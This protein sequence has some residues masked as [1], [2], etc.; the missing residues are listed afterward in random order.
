L[1]FYAAR[2]RR[3]LIDVVAELSIV[4]ESA[5]TIALDANN[6]L[7]LVQAPRAMARCIAKAEESGLCFATVRG[8]NHLG[9][10]GAY[11]LMAARRG[12]GGIAMTNASPLVVPTFGAEARMGT[13]PIAIAVPTGSGP[14]DP[15]LV[16]DMAT[17]AVAWGKIEIARREGKEIPLGWAVDALGAPTTDPHA[18]CW[19][20]PLGGERGHKGYALGT[21]IDVLC[22]PLAGAAWS[23]RI[24]GSRGPEAPASIG[25]AFMAWRIDAFRD[26]DDFFRDIKEMVQE[27]RATPTAAGDEGRSVL[28]PGDPE[29]AAETEHRQSGI[30]LHRAV[31]A[32][33]ITLGD[34]LGVFFPVAEEVFATA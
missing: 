7:G 15:P 2:I 6:G 14:S 25:H 34:E 24:A 27:L 23:A 17:S 11:A 9:I 16:L 3:G 30:P 33:L 18:A 31:V 32:Q 29:L 8:S 13:N 12:L 5:A 1:P 20:T 22:G 10:V 26:P 19:L 28:V 21:M 4:R